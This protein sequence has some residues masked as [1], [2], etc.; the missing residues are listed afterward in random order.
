MMQN[1]FK[2]ISKFLA[3]SAEK[4]GVSL[5]RIYYKGL[6]TVQI[7]RKKKVECW[8]YNS[9]DEVKPVQ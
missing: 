9:R 5:Q 2:T 6:K 3:S 7:F 4:A 1:S 8:G